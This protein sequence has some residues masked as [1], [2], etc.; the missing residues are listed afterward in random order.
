MNNFYFLQENTRRKIRTTIWCLYL[1]H[2]TIRV[3]RKS[4]EQKEVKKAT[5]DCHQSSEA[6]KKYTKNSVIAGTLRRSQ[7]LDQKPELMRSIR[8]YC[9]QRSCYNH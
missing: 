8:I 5:L 2:Y 1:R 9:K 6:G 4:Q 3:L 7:I